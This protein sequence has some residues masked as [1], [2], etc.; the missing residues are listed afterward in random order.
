MRDKLNRKSM[1]QNNKMLKNPDDIN[2]NTIKV[3]KEKFGFT[4]KQ[5]VS[6]FEILDDF[7]KERIDLAIFLGDDKNPK[8]IGEVKVGNFIFPFAEKELKKYMQMSNAKYSFLTNGKEWINYE[9]IDKEL[10]TIPSIPTS[11]ELTNIH[12]DIKK[13]FEQ[14]SGAEHSIRNMFKSMR[15]YGNINTENILQLISLKLY[16]ENYENNENFKQALSELATLKDKLSLSDPIIEKAAYIYRKALEKLFTK[17]DKKFPN[18]HSRFELTLEKTNELLPLIIELSNFSITKSEPIKI[19]RVILE[20]SYTHSNLRFR[21]NSPPKELIKFVHDLFN[22]NEKNKIFLPYSEPAFVLDLL[23]LLNL[24]HPENSNENI[25]IMDPRIKYNQI[26]QIF[27]QLNLPKF[28]K[29]SAEPVFSPDFEKVTTCDNVISCPP[30][31]MLLNETQ[32]F[33]TSKNTTISKD[34]KIKKM[35]GIDLT[36]YG[37]ES[38]HY[39]ISKLIINCKKGT[40]IA[41]VVPQ[42]FLFKSNRYYERI[43]KEIISTCTVQ[44]IIQL[45]ANYFEHT[46]IATA[47]LVLEIGTPNQDTYNIF[48]SVFP[49]PKKLFEQS[50]IEILKII[51]QNFH[52]VRKGISINGSDQHGFAVP[53]EKIIHDNWTVTNKTPEFARMLNIEFKQNISDIAEIIQPTGISFEVNTGGKNIPLIRISDIEDNKI[54]AKIGRSIS[55]ENNSIDKFKKYFIKKGDILLSHRGTIGK[56]VIVKK[57]DEGSIASNQI[58]ILRCKKEII[59]EYFFNYLNSKIFKKQIKSGSGGVLIPFLSIPQFRKCII[60]V[61]PISVQKEKISKTMELE[62]EISEMEAIL[63]K[64]KRKLQE[65]LDNE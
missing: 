10:I 29:L 36:D 49:K 50:N 64:R 43:R 5:I 55:I 59:P 1:K 17:V 60:S 34:E 46:G 32:K 11:K 8:I 20:E 56:T 52:S 9:L 3:L 54:K 23:E 6:E 62:N 2:K 4:S 57:K 27:S 42:G 26:Y 14:I 63:F 47:L 19:A 45:P 22:L 33:G 13:E 31:G 25:T 53:I 35:D 41:L 61:P 7:Q 38:I 39:F 28:E 16:D 44:G 12:S 48:M 37:N 51:I 18:I 58:L 21:W 40:K 24:D 15:V 65:I 30:F